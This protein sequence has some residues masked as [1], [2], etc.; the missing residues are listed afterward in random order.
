[1]CRRLFSIFLFAHHAALALTAPRVRRL[2]A[3]AACATQIASAACS[4]SQPAAGAAG[5]VDAPGV[6][7]LPPTSLAELERRGALHSRYNHAHMHLLMR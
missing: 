7:T 6:H 5:H 3:A 4:T 2:C 1:M